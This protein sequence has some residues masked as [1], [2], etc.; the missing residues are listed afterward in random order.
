MTLAQWFY[1]VLADAILVVHTAFVAFVIV[2][3]VLIWLG[4]W[5][6]WSFVRNFWFRIGHL[7]AIGVVAAESLTGFICPLTT[8]EDRFRLLAGGEER[9][10]GSFIQ[11]WLHRILFYEA[12]PWVF[13]AALFVAVPLR[14]WL[15][16]PP[17]P[18]GTQS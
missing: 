12:S 6:R 9:Y 11:H 3:L 10:A 15:G 4:G 17:R 7:A 14:L 8:W 16:P 5:R 13:Q 2:G 18:G 1:L